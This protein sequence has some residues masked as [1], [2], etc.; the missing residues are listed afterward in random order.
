MKPVRAGR[1]ERLKRLPPAEFEAVNRTVTAA[2]ELGKAGQLA[3]G[4]TLLAAH[5]EQ[6]AAAAEQGVP[7]SGAR[8][9][10]YGLA[11]ENYAWR[12]GPALP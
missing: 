1:L 10:I 6:A 12:Y 4:Y 3:E 7:W 5:W 11:L 9:W 8:R 2:V